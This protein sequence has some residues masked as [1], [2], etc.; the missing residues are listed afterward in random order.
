MRLDR[1][2]S[3]VTPL[4]RSQA[5]KTIRAGRV[6]VNGQCVKRPACAVAESARVSLDGEVLSSPGLRYFMLHKPKGYVCS[7]DDPQHTSALEL[8]HEPTT[9]G[10]HFVGRLDLDTTGLVLITNDGAWS[11]RI[12]A[13]RR[14]APKSYLVTLAEPLK[15]DAVDQLQSGVLLRNEKL[16]TRPTEL[17]LI[18][19]TRIR[20][21]LTEGRYHQVKRML[22]AVG[23]RVVELHRESV[24][25]LTLDADLQPGSYRS[26]TPAEIE[27]AVGYR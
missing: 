1:Y 23:N 4:T 5:G 14:K 20:L 21:T 16:P 15:E 2:L 13:P 11:H 26:L 8:L 19:P 12:S 6:L 17:E 18:S 7:T 24:A 3:S 10:L 22:A 9:K 27:T 25:G